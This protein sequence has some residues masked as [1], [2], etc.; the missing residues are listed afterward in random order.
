VEGNQSLRSKIDQLTGGCPVF[1]SQMQTAR[2]A[3]LIDAPIDSPDNLPDKKR[4][5][6]FCAVGNPQSFFEHLRR[7]GYELSVEKI[8]PDHHSFTQKDID[9]VVHDVQRVGA[10]N[11]VTTA[12]DA[13]KLRSLSFSI[14]CYVLEIEIC[15][16]NMEELM[17]MIRGAAMRP[18][19]G[20]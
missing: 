18:S 13:V 15:I 4:S 12:K 5:A 20:L 17:K 3:P 10:E 8:F 6:A 1:L 2:I 16:E 9:T 14:P 19:A 11:L 7:E